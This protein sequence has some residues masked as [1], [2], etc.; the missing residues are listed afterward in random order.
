MSK[1]KL[2]DVRLM[3]LNMQLL[4]SYVAGGSRVSDLWL[5][6]PYHVSCSKLGGQSASGSKRF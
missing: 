3:E 2:A 6:S 5:C 1:M 4:L